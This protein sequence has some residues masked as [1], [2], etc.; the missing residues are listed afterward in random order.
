MYEYRST[1]LRVV[2]AD[3]LHLHVDLGLDV[4]TRLTVRLL[5]VDAPE[6]RTPEGDAATAWVREQLPQGARVRIGTVKDRR[7]KFGR[8]L[9]SVEYAGPDGEPRDLAAELT[10]RGMARTYTKE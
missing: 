7:E 4:S 8:Y 1:V 3:T 2:D 9:A 5:G 6:A 10:A